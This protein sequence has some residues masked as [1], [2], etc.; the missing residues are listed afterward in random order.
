MFTVDERY[1]SSQD[2]I[3]EAPP[4][5]NIGVRVLNKQ[6][7][8]MLKIGYRMR[9]KSVKMINFWYSGVPR[10]I[11]RMTCDPST[12]KGDFWNRQRVVHRSALYNSKQT[13]S[14]VVL[15][16]SIEMVEN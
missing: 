9:L 7:E 14:G 11:V 16:H 13:H 1:L 3:S 5:S 8:D 6:N 4:T 12:W 15:V 10:H 2:L